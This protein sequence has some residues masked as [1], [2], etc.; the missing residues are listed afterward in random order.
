VIHR[1][2]F[3]RAVLL[4]TALV[5]GGRSTQAQTP[6]PGIEVPRAEGRATFTE[7]M[8][9]RDI[10]AK[11]LSQALHTAVG[12]AL[13]RRLT[14]MTQVTTYED[15]AGVSETFAEIVREAAQGIVTSHAILEEAWEKGEPFTP[16]AT[17]RVAVRATVRRDPASAPPGFRFAVKANQ[18]RFFDRGTPESS[19]ELILSV[20]SDEEVY[21]TVFLVS[22]DSVEVLFPN[23]FMPRV[24]VRAGQKSE[25][26]TLAQRQQG[27]IHLRTIL[28]D[29]VQRRAER[30]VVVATKRYVPYVG[31]AER[32][33]TE[34]A[35]E[36]PLIRATLDALLD[37]LLDIPASER[38]L[39][40][41]A[42]EIV[43]EKR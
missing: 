9:L 24:R 21:L 23:M 6:G 5:V 22:T 27:G 14:A 40:D 3:S 18:A 33:V 38:A 36:V 11:A 31:V 1:H 29:G 12:E 32:R 20:D 13:G 17:Y 43:R 19:D 37:W 7:E 35:G 42:Y 2:R 10:R 28:P 41:V 30:L 8:S 16:G 26:P 15:S 39:G 25:L 34:D 4:G